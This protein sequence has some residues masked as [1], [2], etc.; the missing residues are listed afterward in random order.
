MRKVYGGLELCMYSGGCAGVGQVGIQVVRWVS[1]WAGG[2]PGSAPSVQY[3]G[4]LYPGPCTRTQ[5]HCARTHA[6]PA[7]G[8]IWPGFTSS[9]THLS[10][11]DTGLYSPGQACPWSILSWPGLAPVWVLL[12]GLAT[13]SSVSGWGSLDNS[14]SGDIS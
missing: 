3:P 7:P 11:P 4:P 9:M 2:Y 5:A 6:L 12:A 14:D 1:R 8:L 13:E 10:R